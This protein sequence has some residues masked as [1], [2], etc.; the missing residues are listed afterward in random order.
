MEVTSCSLTVTTQEADRLLP[1]VVVARIVAV[2]GATDETNPLLSTVATAELL[3]VQFKVLS[4]ASLGVIDAN[5]CAVSGQ[6][7]RC[8]QISAV[9]CCCSNCRTSWSHR[10]DK[11][12]D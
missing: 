5:N 6:L 8:D 11:S 4:V 10:G 12:V 1:S 2:P 9:G 3:L 7:T